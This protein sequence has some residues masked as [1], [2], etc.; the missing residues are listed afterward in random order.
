MADGI[1]ESEV[2]RGFERERERDVRSGKG[3]VFEI[4]DGRDGGVDG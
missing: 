3:S 2:G 4:R 1:E